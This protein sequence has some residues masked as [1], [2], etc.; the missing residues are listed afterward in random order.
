MR[1]RARQAHGY[2]LV[3]TRNRDV[4]QQRL[5]FR[6]VTLREREESCLEAAWYGGCE[7][8]RQADSG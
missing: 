7:Q 2:V 4:T 1:G 6:R 3:F 8:S 5:T